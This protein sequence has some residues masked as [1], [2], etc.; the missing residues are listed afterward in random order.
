M[1]LCAV[2]QGRIGATGHLNTINE[3]G[4]FFAVEMNMEKG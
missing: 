1:W 2:G 4:S 3:N